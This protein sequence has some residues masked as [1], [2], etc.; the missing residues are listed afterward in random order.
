MMEGVVTDHVN[1]PIVR[2]TAVA[3]L[4]GL[5]NNDIAGQIMA[6]TRWVRENVTYVRDPL[7][8]E[9]IVTP[10]RMLNSWFVGGY[11]AGDCDDHVVL[12]NSLLGSI[13]V[14]TKAVGVKFGRSA[15]YNHVISG[16]SYNG[17]LQLVDPCA[18]SGNQQAYND[19][20]II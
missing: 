8:G 6:I 1:D 14:P 9:Y 11:M 19:L 13:G 4:R 7:E 2:E 10:D 5:G 16:V 3:I 12:L 17:R 15:E 20:L 18:K